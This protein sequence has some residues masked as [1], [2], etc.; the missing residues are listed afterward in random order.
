MT[1]VKIMLRLQ[2]IDLGD[3]ASA[4]RIPPELCD[5]FWSAAGASRLS[6]S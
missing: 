1:T 4:E 2:G 6:P 3:P 5:F